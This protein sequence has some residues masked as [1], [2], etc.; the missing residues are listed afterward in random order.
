MEMYSGRKNESSG[1][2]L[3]EDVVTQLLSKIADPRR[4]EIYFANIFI[5]DNLLKK[6]ADFRI[7][8]KSTVRSNCIGQ[9]HLLDNNTLAKET[10][11]AMDFGSDVTVFICHWND[12]AVV[13]VASNHQTQ[14]PISYTNRYSKSEKKR[15]FM[16]PNLLL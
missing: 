13:S 11:R 12:N 1:M 16:L 5:S 2:P 14:Q 15:K 7:G 6:L 10:R 4:Y 9:L 3:C 8:T